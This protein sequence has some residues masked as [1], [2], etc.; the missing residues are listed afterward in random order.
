MMF[1]FMRTWGENIQAQSWS[2]NSGW[3]LAQGHSPCIIP[4][5]PSI[6]SLLIMM[7]R[8]MCNVARSHESNNIQLVS[9]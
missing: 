6:C 9:P 5:A 4:G 1:L 8:A 2:V 7:E 3:M